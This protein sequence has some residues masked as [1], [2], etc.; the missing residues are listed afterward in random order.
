MDPLSL[1]AGAAAG[2]LATIGLVLFVG[3][4][5]LRW[6]ERARRGERNG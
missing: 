2:S 5:Q 6:R 3:W 1:V 4:L